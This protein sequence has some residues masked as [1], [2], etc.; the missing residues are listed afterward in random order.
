MKN[1]LLYEHPSG[2]LVIIKRRDIAAFGM[3][4]AA[5]ARGKYKVY[6]NVY[7]EKI[8]LQDFE[9]PDEAKKWMKEQAELLEG[10]LNEST[11]KK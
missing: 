8:W 5:G 1:L 10:L 2:E 6:A 7:G 3:T 4:Y 11:G 9:T